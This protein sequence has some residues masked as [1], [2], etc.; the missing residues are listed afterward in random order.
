[1]QISDFPGF[2]VITCMEEKKTDLNEEIVELG[3]PQN[4]VPSHEEMTIPK[5]SRTQQR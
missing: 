2:F 3:K 4:K 1:M 5:F